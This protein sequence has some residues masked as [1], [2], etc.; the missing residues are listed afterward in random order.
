M[1]RILPL[2]ALL[3]LAACSKESSDTVKDVTVQK[4]TSTPATAAPAAGEPVAATT[5]D[6]K[7]VV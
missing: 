5:V 1:N 3:A 6:R 4:G 2:V 7:S